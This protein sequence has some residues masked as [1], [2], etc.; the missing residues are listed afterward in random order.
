MSERAENWVREPALHRK[1]DGWLFLASD[2]SARFLDRTW[3]HGARNAYWLAIA[4]GWLC[5]R[6][7]I[8]FGTG[9]VNGLRWRLLPS[10]GD[11]I[12]RDQGGRCSSLAM[13]IDVE[14]ARRD[15]AAQA[16]EATP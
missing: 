11:W 3:Y 8:L 5:Y 6:I 15:S 16:C 2:G 10:A 4:T 1:K 13:F 14:L 9:S 12:Y 7:I